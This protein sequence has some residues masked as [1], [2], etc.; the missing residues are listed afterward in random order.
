MPHKYFD[1]VRMAWLL[2]TESPLYIALGQRSCWAGSLRVCAR[3][4]ILE[5]CLPYRLS[6]AVP[7]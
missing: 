1:H 6:A 3:V 7:Y 4:P 5:S 2:P